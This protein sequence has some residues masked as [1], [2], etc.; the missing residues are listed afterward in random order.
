MS[1]MA[2]VDA[3][4]IEARVGAWMAGC[5]KLVTGFA[6]NRDIYSEFATTL[7]GCEVRKPSS[8][9]SKERAF[10]LTIKRGFG[11]DAILGAGYGMG[12]AKFYSRCLENKSLRPM[13]DDKTYTFSFVDQLISTY[14][15]EYHQIPSLWR[16]LEGK[17]RYVVEHPDEAIGYGK[18]ELGLENN[19]F[20]FWNDRGTVN[21]QLPSSRILYYPHAAIN[22]QDKTLRYEHGH[23]WG[24]TL[25]ENFDQATS[26]DLL[27]TWIR[28]VE[29]AGIPVVHHVYDEI[30]GL[31]PVDEAKEAQE[32]IEK[33]MCTAPDWAK[34]L[35]LAAEGKTSLVYVK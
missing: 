14:R 20:E 7:F 26:R 6:Q 21:V 17:F 1:I 3:A 23:L 22:K 16:V 33:I 4:Q 24:G 19:M 18:L 11:K 35:P 30:I 29:E 9:D 13:F 28:Q 31:V 32:T 10:D 34:G 25:L 8:S 27:V 15:K 5:Q 2:L 12:S